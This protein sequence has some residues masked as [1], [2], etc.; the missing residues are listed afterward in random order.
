MVPFLS[1]SDPLQP[2]VLRAPELSAGS[3]SQGRTHGGRG[4]RP[5]GPNKHCIFRISSAKLLCIFEVCFLVFCYVGGLRKP[6]V[7]SIFRAL[8]ATMHIWKKY[9]PPPPEEILGA[10]LPG[11][12]DD[13]G[14]GK[15]LHWNSDHA[16][17]CYRGVEL[18]KLPRP[19]AERSYTVDYDRLK[20]R[21]VLIQLA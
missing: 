4:A 2:D 13:E 20:R 5:L 6:Y 15:A 9:R 7:R 3:G 16:S 1:R 12:S 17:Q 21:T 10:P 8:L 18:N 19:G 11:G 14:R